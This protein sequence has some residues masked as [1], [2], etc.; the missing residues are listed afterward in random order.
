ME[1]LITLPSRKARDSQLAESKMQ[2][3]ILCESPAVHGHHQ[4]LP[5]S[6]SRAWVDI[7]HLRPNLSLLSL[8]G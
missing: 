5:L 6:A 8:T 3:S 7:S 4:A 1:L 2:N